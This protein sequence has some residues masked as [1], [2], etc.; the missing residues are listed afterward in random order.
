MIY[1]GFQIV[2]YAGMLYGGWKWL[3]QT[4]FQALKDAK[5]E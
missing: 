3:G 2:C 5:P 1:V 4:L